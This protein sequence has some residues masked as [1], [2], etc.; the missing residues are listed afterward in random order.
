MYGRSMNKEQVAQVEAAIKIMSEEISSTMRKIFT[1]FPLYKTTI[2][3][4]TPDGRLN[5][6]NYNPISDTT[7]AY[8]PLKDKGVS[9]QP[10]IEWLERNAIA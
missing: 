6:F 1:E 10:I 7:R 3:F 4:Y 8:E 9:Y 5:L 2:S